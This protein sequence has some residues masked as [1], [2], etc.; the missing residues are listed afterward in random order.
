[1]ESA[2]YPETF[3]RRNLVIV[4]PI[5]EERTFIHDVYMGELFHG[6][7]RRESRDALVAIA[8][9]MKERDEIDGLRDG[10]RG[11]DP[12]DAGIAPGVGADEE[13]LRDGRTRQAAH[14]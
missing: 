8:A 7:I 14:A 5:E 3:A 1:M 6:V 12:I 4:V 10:Q 9:K 13:P 2:F 11:A